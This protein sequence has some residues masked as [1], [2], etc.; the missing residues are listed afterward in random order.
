MKKTK[1][2]PN[3]IRNERLAGEVLRSH[4]ADVIAIPSDKGKDFCIIEKN[5]YLN[6]CNVTS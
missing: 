6:C 2:Q 5:V 4:N 1:L 3:I